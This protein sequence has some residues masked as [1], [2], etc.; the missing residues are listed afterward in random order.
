MRGI[1]S[2]SVMLVLLLSAVVS[3]GD[4]TDLQEKD[5]ATHFDSGTRLYQDGNCERAAEE[6]RRAHELRPS[7]K[8]AYNMVSSKRLRNGMEPP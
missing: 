5:A 6:F 4:P 1:C 8:I 3:V 7:W 2:F